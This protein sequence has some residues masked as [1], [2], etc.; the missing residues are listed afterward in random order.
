MLEMPGM[1]RKPTDG[2]LSQSKKDPCGLKLERPWEGA[3]QAFWC[4][5]H[6]T[7]HPIPGM[8][9]QSLMFLCWVLVLSRFD[10]T[11]PFGVP[12]PPL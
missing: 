10:P 7:T 5:H 9:L 11:P 4:S 2:D 3:S 1:L 6:E 12:I 8:E